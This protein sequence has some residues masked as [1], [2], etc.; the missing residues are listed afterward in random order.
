MSLPLFHFFKIINIR[1]IYNEYINLV[2]SDSYNNINS[3]GIGELSIFIFYTIDNFIKSK[4][5]DITKYEIN[6]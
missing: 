1:E 4:I 5:K 2:P 6:Y 3:S